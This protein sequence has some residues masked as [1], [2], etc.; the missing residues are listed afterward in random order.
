MSS[1]SEV[2]GSEAY[3]G[4]LNGDGAWQPSAQGTEFLAVD[5]QYN[6]YIFGIQTQG[7]GDGYVETYR[8]IY[9]MDNTTGLILYS[10]DGG[11]AKVG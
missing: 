11:D 5:L 6:R 8:I 1:S 7:Q 3:R 2:N 9:Q 4:R 10:E